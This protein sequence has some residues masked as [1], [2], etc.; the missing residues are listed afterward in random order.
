M[1]IRHYLLIIVV[2]TSSLLL[3]ACTTSSIK[4]NERIVSDSEKNAATLY[5]IRPEP[6]R[7]RGVADSDI[8]IELDQKLAAKLSAGEYIAVKVKP[9]KTEVS[10]WSYTYLTSKP[11]PE[12]VHR[13]AEFI[14]DAGK[15]YIIHTR[16]TQEEFRGIYFTPEEITTAEAKKMLHR[17]KPH[18]SLAKANPIDS[19]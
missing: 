3:G 13:S 17:L 5:F 1:S 11:M 10:L 6:L 9:G 7:T 16:F 14:F 8:N 19:L 18:G 12:E 4:K 15:N 2:L